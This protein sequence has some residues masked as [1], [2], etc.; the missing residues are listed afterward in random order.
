MGSRTRHSASPLGLA[1]ADLWLR[2]GQD[3]RDSVGKDCMHAEQMG[4]A[5]VFLCSPAA[6]GITG[7]VLTIDYG[8][9]VSARAGTF[10]DPIVDFLDSI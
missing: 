8:Q 4:D 6:S 5:L 10:P 3:Y 7:E 9:V 2:T 1:N